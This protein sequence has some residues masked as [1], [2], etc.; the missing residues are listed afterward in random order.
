MAAQEIINETCLGCT[1]VDDSSFTVCPSTMDYA[2]LGLSPDQT[3]QFTL[4]WRLHSMRHY[5][6][7]TYALRPRYSTCTGGMGNEL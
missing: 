5:T 6:K 3:R 2:V 1:G 4:R 7:G